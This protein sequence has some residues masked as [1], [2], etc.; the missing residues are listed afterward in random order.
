MHLYWIGFLIAPI[1]VD[2]QSK[3]STTPL[4]MRGLWCVAQWS[5][6]SQAYTQTGQAF[7]YNNDTFTFNFLDNS[8]FTW[9]NHFVAINNTDGSGGTY[10]ILTVATQGPSQYLNKTLCFWRRLI[11][12]DDIV[13]GRQSNGTCTPTFENDTAPETI[14]YTRNPTTCRLID[15]ENTKIVLSSTSFEVETLLP[16][17]RNLPSAKR[18]GLVFFGSSSIVK[19]STL[20]QDFPDYTTLNRGFGGSTLL[21]CYQQFKRIIYPLEPSILVIYAGENDIA[22]GQPAIVV[23]SIFRQLIPAIR[24]FYPNMPIAYISLKPSPSRVSKMGQMNDT[25]NRIRNDIVLLFRE[26]TFIDIWPDMLL[27]NGQPNPDL[28]LSDNLHMNSKGYAIWTKAVTIYLESVFVKRAMH[29]N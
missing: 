14:R 4:F 13:S 6:S 22:D 26:V 28:F 15:D 1:L 12:N 5:Q 16:F 8:S 20:A 10:Q 11:A 3:I 2:G 19:W 27:P 24:H 29:T 7:F 17:D 23:Q 18:H 25:N 9:I 21:Q